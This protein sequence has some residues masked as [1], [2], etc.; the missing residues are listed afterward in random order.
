MRSCFTLNK[1]QCDGQQSNIYFSK[2]VDQEQV[3]QT[4][5]SR[6]EQNWHKKLVSSHQI[7][8]SN[9]KMK[10]RIL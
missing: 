8:K 10:E 2:L 5:H 3:A 7:I 9:V 6:A 1:C 4:F